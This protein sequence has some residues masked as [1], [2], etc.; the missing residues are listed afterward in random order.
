MNRKPVVMFGATSGTVSRISRFEGFV[1]DLAAHD[2][3]EVVPALEKVQAAVDEGYYAA[4][5]I[6]YEAAPALDESLAAKKSGGFPLLWFGVY[7]TRRWM[8]VAELSVAEGP[9]PYRLSGWRRSISKERYRDAVHRIRNYIAAGDLYQVNY[10]IRESCDFTGEVSEYFRRLSRSQATPYAALLD[11]DGFS[12]LSA[13]PELFFRLSDGRLTVRPMKGTAKRGRWEAEDA[14]LAAMLR[15]NEKERAEN[16]MIVDL[17]RNDLGRISEIGSVAV[18]SLFDVET[19]GTVHQMTSTVSSRLRPECGLGDIFRALF[20]CG[21]ITGAPKKRSMEVISELEDSPRGLYTGCVGYIGP[22]MREALFSVAIRTLVINKNDGK[23]ELGVGSGITWYSSP[24]SEFEECLAKGMFAKIP[25][26][27]FTLIESILLVEGSGYF[28]LE[29]HLARISQSARYFGFSLDTDS[30]RS[31]LEALRRRVTG[32]N[33][34][35]IILSRD[36][37]ASFELEPISQDDKPAYPWIAFAEARVDSD[38]PFLYHKTS[39]RDLY[40]HEL[41]KRP[42]CVDVIFINERGEV[43]EG[44]NNN[45]VIRR[46]GMLLTPPLTSGLLPGT[47]RAQLLEDGEISEAVIMPSDVEKADEIYL[48]NSVRKWRLVRLVNGA[49]K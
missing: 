6:S 11:L 45:L 23:C 37:S 33:K 40:L 46:D 20:P 4:G 28:L 35:R 15:N 10:T 27:E 26:I 3:T 25:P 43:T 44:A 47:F 21:S 2:T 9:S 17:L 31:A 30:M 18:E 48:I 7:R 36:G 16:L 42:G 34:V 14:E 8:P 19:L 24:E 13:S 29:R 41:K 22:R 12:I 32:C 38:N 49:A 1:F 39:N 5:F